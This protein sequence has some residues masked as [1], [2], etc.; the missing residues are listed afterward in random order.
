MRGSL[1]EISNVCWDWVLG[2]SLRDEMALLFIDVKGAGKVLG[3]YT[4]NGR[5]LYS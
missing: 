2:A 1:V 3:G 4:Y 5:R